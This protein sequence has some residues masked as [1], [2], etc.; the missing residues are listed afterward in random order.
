MNLEN[1]PFGSIIQGVKSGKYDLGMS[2]FTINPDRVKQ[3]DMVSYYSAGTQLG[4]THGQPDGV[5]PDNACGKKVAVQKDTVQVDDVT[6]RS[7]KCTDAGKPAIAIEQFTLQSDV[8][9]RG[10]DRQG[11]RRARRLAGHRL[12]RSSRPTASSQ[13][14]GDV[15]DSAPYGIVV[16][17]AQG[18]YAKAVQ[19][20]VQKLIDSGAYTDDPEEVGRRGRR[21]EDGR[22]QPGVMSDTLTRGAD[23]AAR[24]AQGRTRPA[25]RPAGPPS[26]VIAVLVA[27]AVNSVVTNPN[28]QWGF[29]RDNAFTSR[30]LQGVWT[31]LWLT[32]A[33]M[34]MGVVLGIVL[35]VMRLSPNPVLSGSAWFYIWVFRGTPVL[36]QLTIWAAARVALPHRSPSA[37]R[38]ARGGS[39]STP[40]TSI[41]NAVAALLGLGLNE[42]AYMSEIIRA[43]MLSVDEGQSEAASALGMSRMQTLRRI[44]LPQAMRVVVPPTGNETISMLKTTSLVSARPVRGAV[45][46]DVSRSA[47][48][49]SRCSPRWS[50]PA[51]GTSP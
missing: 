49:P 48:G 44:V 33:A 15:Y 27:M 10:R 18:D 3:V 13:Q 38:S 35:A 36:V 16:P 23:T 8:D 1:A 43:G 40:A 29:I 41:P 9:E 19:G 6:A 14:V 11:R 26:S 7:K 46:P 12:R 24:A 34:S 21:G 2:S 5:T 17:K 39:P 4:R 47:A 51:S 50:W 45:L 25:P 22:G 28:W 42:A 30:S 31:T 32:A 20:A 37:S